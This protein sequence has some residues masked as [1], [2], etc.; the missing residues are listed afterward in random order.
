MAEGLARLSELEED[1]DIYPRG[2]VSNMHV[3]DLLYALEAGA[4]LPPPVVDTKSRKIVDGFHR[5]RALRRWHGTD[6]AEIT[7]DFQ[8][9]ADDVAMLLESARLN[10]RHGLPLQRLDQTHVAIKARKFGAADDEIASAL[11]VTPERLVRIEIK[12]AKSEHGLVPVKY[13]ARHLA[14][15]FINPAQVDA[16][17][18]M[19]GGTARSKAA[20]LLSLLRTGIAPV[21]SDPDL[22]LSLSEL[23]DQINASLAAF[24]DPE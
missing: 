14:G 16:L 22:R 2:N 5:V 8:D 18:R 1:P 20:E 9:Y 23:V 17:R 19:R 4:T 6:E 15:T 11:G 13:G 3:A 7:V 24:G 12:V 21:D 10:A